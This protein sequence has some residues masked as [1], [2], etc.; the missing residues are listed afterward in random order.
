MKGLFAIVLF[1]SF[2]CS[3]RVII[4]EAEI[5]PG[6]FYADGSYLPFTGKCSVVGRNGGGVLEEFT[7]KKGRLHGKAQVWYKSGRM[8]RKGSFENGKLSGMWVHWD[9]N[10]NIMAETTYRDGKWISTKY[11]SR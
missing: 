11:P 1:C 7:Y 8:K 3:G 6:I 9:E 5:M 4:T 10:G 2:A